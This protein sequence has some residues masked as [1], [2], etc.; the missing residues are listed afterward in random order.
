M[1]VWGGNVLDERV[2]CLHVRCL[3]HVGCVESS[4]G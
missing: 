3:I 2:T 1:C 4:D